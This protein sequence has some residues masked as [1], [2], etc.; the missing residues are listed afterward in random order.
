MQ[1]GTD[2]EAHPP[3]SLAVLPGTGD[4]YRMNGKA[5]NSARLPLDKGNFSRWIPTKRS[6][7]ATAQFW[8]ALRSISAE[9]VWERCSCPI[10]Y[11]L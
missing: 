1:T 8:R 11:L 3:S 4:A 2:G 6:F 10:Y 7:A 9:W 5:R